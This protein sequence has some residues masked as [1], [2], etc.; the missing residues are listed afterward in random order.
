MSYT[1]LFFFGLDL[2]GTA[3]VNH[4]LKIKSC[5]KIYR[6]MNAREK[7][8]NQNQVSKVFGILTE[9]KFKLVV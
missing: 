9:Q 8:D 2:C 7:K 3:N 4:H 5:D 6:K 1:L